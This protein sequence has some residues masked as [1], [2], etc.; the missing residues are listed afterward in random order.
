MHLKKTHVN[1]SLKKDIGIITEFY[2]SMNYGATLQAYALRKVISGKGYSCEQIRYN[3]DKRIRQPINRKLI[4]LIKKTIRN[5]K[6][7]LNGQVFSDFKI[8]KSLR[9]R[10]KAFR[11]FDLEKVPHSEKIYN[12]GNIA[13]ATKYSKGFIAGSDQIWNPVVI[14]YGYSL[15][16]VH[17]PVLKESYAASLSVEALSSKNIKKYQQFLNDF[18]YISVRE[19][20]AQKLFNSIG[21][22]STLVLDPT[23]LLTQSEWEQCISGVERFG[24]RKPF[25]FCYFIENGIDA[26]EIA[27]QYAKKHNLA[28]VTIPYMKSKYRKIDESFGDY[29]LY[30]VSPSEFL[31]LI[32]KADYIF[33]DSFHGSIFSWVFKK[34]FVTFQRGYDGGLGLMSSRIISLF[35]ILNCKERFLESKSECNIQQIEGILGVEY[36]HD[37]ALFNELFRNSQVFLEKV[38]STIK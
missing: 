9:R 33:T 29:Q 23:L 10:N 14:N 2:N 30:D 25:L 8:R 37:S 4:Q 38:L 32:K 16:F 22:S 24:I 28:I 35:E 19:K 34:Q 20:Q 27:C 12:A 7:L 26:R 6:S 17:H 1:N 3:V 15:S 5:A 21:I 13:K 11:E 31:G 18:S 36:K